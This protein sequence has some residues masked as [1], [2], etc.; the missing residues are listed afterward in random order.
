MRS[1]LMHAGAAAAAL[2]RQP[3]GPQPCWPAPCPI[4]QPTNK[5]PRMDPKEAAKA[6]AA[7]SR[8]ANKAAKLAKE[9]AG[10]RKLSAFF[11]PSA[12]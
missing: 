11:K 7:E 2:P 5:R 6:K 3:A 12:K 10:M 8:Q 4:P 9:A 1:L